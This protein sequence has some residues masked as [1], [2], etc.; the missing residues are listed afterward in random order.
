MRRSKAVDAIR[1]KGTNGSWG[2][3]ETVLGTLALVLTLNK[4]TFKQE[5]YDFTFPLK[6]LCL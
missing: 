1:D 2:H 3:T 4:E 5:S 6:G